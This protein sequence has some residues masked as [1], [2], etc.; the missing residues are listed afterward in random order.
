MGFVN[1]IIDKFIRLQ[2]K[3]YQEAEEYI[4]NGEGKVSLLRVVGIDGE[5]VLLKVEGHTIKRASEN[6]VPEDI[7]RCT[8][9]TF[10]DIISGDLS[11]RKAITRGHFTIENAH[12]KAI[13]M[14]E[15][16]KW[17]TAFDRLSS[18]VVKLAKQ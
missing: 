14:I 16:Q 7:F 8:S 13:D 4:T 9:D 5:T 15:M 18:L 1:A 11:M 3:F 17:S 10:L 2:D 12:T 6:D